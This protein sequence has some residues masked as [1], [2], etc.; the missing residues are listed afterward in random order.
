[1]KAESI[2]QIYTNIISEFDTVQN[3]VVELIK[4]GVIIL[5]R[6][7]QPIYSNEKAK[8]ICQQLWNNHFSSD[9][10]P[11]AIYELLNWLSKHPG[12]E[13][14]IFV[15]DHQLNG[16][17]IIRIRARFLEF[18]C[19]PKLTSSDHPW[20]LLFLEDRNAILQDELRIEQKKYDLTERELEV[21]NLLSQSLSY[22]EISNRLQISLNTVKFH[23][24][25]INLKKQNHVKPKTILKIDQR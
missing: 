2:R 4:E 25:K 11:P 22:Q 12:F 14:E 3:M 6:N 5:S 17:Q 1:M 18:N 9:K 8:G 19:E 24:K 13:G 7:L 23:A 15:M 20:L 16:E 10:F 21:L